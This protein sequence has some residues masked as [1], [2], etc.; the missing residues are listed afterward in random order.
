MNNFYT[1]VYKVVQQIPKGKVTSYGRIAKMLGHP[2]AAR[3]VGY[4]LS[5]LRH[6]ESDS[7]YTSKTVPWHRVVN[8]Q[9]RISINHRET[10]ANRQALILQEEGVEIDPHLKINLDQ[11]LWQGLHLME[12]DDILKELS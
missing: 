9:G 6:P 5:A 3:A 12:L 2:N 1:K 7:P 4:A 11:H 10:T 8:S